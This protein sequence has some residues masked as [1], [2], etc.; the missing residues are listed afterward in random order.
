MTRFYVTSN[1]QHD[2]LIE[3][4]KS[5][6]RVWRQGNMSVEKQIEADR[7]IEWCNHFLDK[8]SVW[9][10]PVFWNL[11]DDEISTI[12]WIILSYVDE[13]FVGLEKRYDDL[14]NQVK[15]IS[16]TLKTAA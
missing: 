9:P 5:V 4:I 16:L 12:K 15:E 11:T 14:I 10:R 8:F 13:T 6:S 7:I 3:A 2:A 1:E